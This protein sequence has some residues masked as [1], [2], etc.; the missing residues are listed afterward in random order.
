MQHTWILWDMIHKN[1]VLSPG[2]LWALDAL[3]GIDPT[4]TPPAVSQIPG[5]LMV[6]LSIGILKFYHWYIKHRK[7]YVLSGW[8]TAV[9]PVV[10][11]RSKVGLKSVPCNKNLEWKTLWSSLH[12]TLDEI[13]MKLR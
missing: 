1:W 9:Y 5:W 8:K 2:L 13:M 10:I 4:G 7:L 11:V 12:S 3:D 6:C